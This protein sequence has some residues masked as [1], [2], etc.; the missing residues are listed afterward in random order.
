MLL[1]IQALEVQ[2]GK[3]RI[4]HGVSLDLGQRPLAVVGRNGMGKTTLC[5]AIMGMAPVTG[6]S[7]RLDG[8]ELVGLKPHHIARLGLALV[9]QGRRVFPSLTVEE[10]LR[11]VERPGA[12]KWTRERIYALF[13]R[14]HLRRRNTGAQL[15]GGEQQMLAIARALLCNPRLMIM[16]EPTEGLA[17][18]MIAQV[19]Q[20]MKTIV[21]EDQISILLVEQNLGVA[22]AVA[23]TLS[24]MVN[25]CIAQ[26]LGSA[27]LAGDHQLQQSLLGVRV[28]TAGLPARLLRPVEN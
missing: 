11:L 15:S 13:P 2:Y 8:M 12:A 6:G 7:V 26:T 22:T 24:V 27:Q 16:D 10:H 9:P 4:L 14:L 19:V 5:H 20:M 25:G 17:P 18:V 23:D 1:Q 28:A 3:S 21:D